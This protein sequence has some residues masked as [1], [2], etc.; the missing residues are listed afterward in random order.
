[1]THATLTD[2]AAF[3]GTDR[4]EGLWD[5]SFEK[6]VITHVGE[7]G[8]NPPAG[9]R[10]DGTGA[11]LLPGLI[12]AHVHFL[13]PEEPGTLAGFGV[14]TALDM[15]TWPAAFVSALRAAGTG[16]DIRSSGAPIAGTGG[17]HAHIPG[18]P[19]DSLVGTADAARRTVAARVGQGVDHIKP[20]LERPGA[21]GPDLATATAVVEA[22]HEAG[23]R[24][25]AHAG[26]TAAYALAAEAGIDVLTHAPSTPTSTTN[27]C[28]PSAG[29]DTSS[30]PR[31][32]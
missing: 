7:S 26:N 18:F 31:S 21:G 4:L 30:S 23:L 19:A 15:G 25:V 11:T 28:R 22:A 9:Q 16:A 6:G 14:T 2:V 1:M 3:D 27:W 5:V 10:I 8:T 17:T 12:D 20:I 32:P 29:V 13:D 24:V